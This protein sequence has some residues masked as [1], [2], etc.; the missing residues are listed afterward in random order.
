MTSFISAEKWEA[1]GRAS[2]RSRSMRRVQRDS[3]RCR[4][5]G[6]LP[7]RSMHQHPACQLDL[8]ELDE[9]CRGLSP[10]LKNCCQVTAEKNGYTRIYQQKQRRGS[11]CSLC[12]CN[13]RKP[14]LSHPA[15]G[16]GWTAAVKKTC[17]T[18]RGFIPFSRLP[19]LFS[20]LNISD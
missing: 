15:V 20:R 14:L 16:C 5:P 13:T 19:M 18:A 3:L 17:T 6:Q 9:T 12:F 1:M 2:T 7:S 10:P 11:Q 8:C 4:R